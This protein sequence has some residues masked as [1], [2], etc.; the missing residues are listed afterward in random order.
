MSSILTIPGQVGCVL[1][2]VNDLFLV[3][4]F[5]RVQYELF[6][7]MLLVTVEDARFLVLSFVF[8]HYELFGHVLRCTFTVQEQLQVVVLVTVPCNVI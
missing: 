7:A 6:L 8:V 1:L 5:V 2:L 4:P 3:E